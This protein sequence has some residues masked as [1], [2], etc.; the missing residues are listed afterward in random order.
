MEPTRLELAIAAKQE[1]RERWKH[2]RQRVDEW[3]E[4]GKDGKKKDD[5]DDGDDDDNDINNNM[6][7]KT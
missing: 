3:L 6:L 1:E 4:V 2:Q 5:D 7:S